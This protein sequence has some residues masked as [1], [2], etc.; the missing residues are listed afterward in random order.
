MKVKDGLKDRDEAVMA[1]QWLMFT[2]THV[3]VSLTDSLNKP[4]T[5]EQET[6]GLARQLVNPLQRHRQRVLARTK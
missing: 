1:Y 3:L 4:W 5:E 6:H 2:S